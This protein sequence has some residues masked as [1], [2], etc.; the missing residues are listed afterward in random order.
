MVHAGRLAD[1]RGTV[2]M[3]VYL[4]TGALIALYE[5]KDRNHESAKETLQGLLA[6]DV[7]LVTGWHTLVEFLDGLVHHYDQARVA[8]ELDRL[9]SSPR[10]TVV[11]TDALRS[12]A[13]ETFEARRDWNVDLSDCLSF[14]VMEEE[15][16]DQ[17][18]TF[19]SDFEKPGFEI[20]PG[21]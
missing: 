6:D 18:F 12:Q 20:V 4:D 2:L 14:T 3:A 10:L 19:D 5:S 16:I 15:G 8:D 1:G 9:R 13:V 7:S 11:D 17:V 21:G